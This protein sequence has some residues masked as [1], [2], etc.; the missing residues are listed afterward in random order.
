MVKYCKKESS[1]EVHIY[2]LINFLVS[3]NC[4][5]LNKS[6]ISEHRFYNPSFCSDSFLK[7]LLKS[8]KTIF[9][10]TQSISVT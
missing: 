7:F 2:L 1:D 5:N 8:V 9:I 10:T 6:L 3:L 4:I